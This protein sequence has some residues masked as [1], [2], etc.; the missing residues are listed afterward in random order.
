MD[1]P[2]PKFSISLCLTDCSPGALQSISP[3]IWRTTQFVSLQIITRPQ[4]WPASKSKP[5][6]NLR[7]SALLTVRSGVNSEAAATIFHPGNFH[8]IVLYAPPFHF[9]LADPS[10]LDTSNFSFTPTVGD[11]ILI[12]CLG[13]FRGAISINNSSTSSRGVVLAA[14]VLSI[15]S[16][17][18]SN[19]LISNVQLDSKAAHLPN[20]PLRPE[21]C[22]SHASVEYRVSTVISRDT[23][24]V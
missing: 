7:Y 5:R 13:C 8:I 19:L 24:I 10:K 12:F 3:R 2:R 14:I 1:W 22:K 21:D 6:C 4:A 20:L 23:S 11:G 18:F 16:F 15:S 17:P 9:T